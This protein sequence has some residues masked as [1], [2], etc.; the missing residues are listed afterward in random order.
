MSFRTAILCIDNLT[1][2]RDPSPLSNKETKKQKNIKTKTVAHI[3]ENIRYNSSG[4][5]WRG[6][7]PRPT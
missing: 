7:R 5:H 2:R 4:K 1:Q 3:N 6:I